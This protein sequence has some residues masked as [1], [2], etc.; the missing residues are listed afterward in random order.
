MKAVA[1]LLAAVLL[2]ALRAPAPAVSAPGPNNPAPLPKGWGWLLAA[3]TV[4]GFDGSAGTATLAIAGQGRGATF[5]G[6]TQWRPQTVAGSQVVH[7]LPSTVISDTGNQPAT[8]AGVRAGVPATVWAVVRP[9]AAVLA[10]KLR[11]GSESRPPPGRTTSAEGPGG[12]TGAV[13]HATVSMLELL[14][15]QGTL[16]TVIVTTATTVRNPS[17]NVVRSPAIAPH[18][19]LRVEGTVNSDGS[20]AATRIDLELEAAVAPHVSGSV[21]QVFQDVGGFVMGGVAIATAPGCYYFKG[22][23]P[24]A[25]PQL[26][27]GQPAVA[28]GTPIVSGATPVGL[29]AQVVAMR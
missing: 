11:L 23:G 12:V 2:A 1:V 16:R 25:W 27:P 28:Y 6:G 22:S 29:R 19:V 21:D 17:G 13:M 20:V 10:L 5:E 9:D 4:S 7:I 14:T 18:D 24:G 3:G 26:V 8:I 15:S